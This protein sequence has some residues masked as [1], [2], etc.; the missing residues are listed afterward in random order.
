LKLT[1]DAHS[2][3]KITTITG[4]LDKTRAN[5]LKAEDAQATAQLTLAFQKSEHEQTVSSL[6][7]DIASLRSKPNMESVVAELEEKN[8][9]LEEMLRC[10]CEEVEEND[11]RFIE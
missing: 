1:A 3:H 5:L 7:R 2:E 6:R 4:T 9:E 8:R 10:K 11:D